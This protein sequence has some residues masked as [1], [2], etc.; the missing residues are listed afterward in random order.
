VDE[1]VLVGEAEIRSALAMVIDTEHQLVEG[2]AAVAFAAARARRADIKG[3]RIAILS[4][5]GNISSRTLAEA[6][7][8]VTSG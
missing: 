4:C 7:S 2:A 8:G 5:G 3:L 1:W 6:L